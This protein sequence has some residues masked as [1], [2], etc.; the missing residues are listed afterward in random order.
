MDFT[1]TTVAVSIFGY[2]VWSGVLKGPIDADEAT[3]HVDEG[4][5]KIPTITL[6]LTKVYGERWEESWLEAVGVDGVL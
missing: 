1:A 4:A 5:D 6:N 2:V 3:W